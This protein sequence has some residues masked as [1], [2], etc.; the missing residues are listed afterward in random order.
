M[1]PD[2]ILQNVAPDQGQHC[3]LH[4]KQFLDTGSKKALEILEELW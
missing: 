4:Y 2:Q 3:L 1:D